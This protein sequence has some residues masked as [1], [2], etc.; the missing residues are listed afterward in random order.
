M[1]HYQSCTWP[2]AAF[3]SHRR[4]PGKVANNTFAT[5][6]VRICVD[7]GDVY[8]CVLQFDTMPREVTAHVEAKFT[9]LLLCSKHAEA[10]FVAAAPVIFCMC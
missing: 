6:A 1:P 8:K 9:D 2:S 4:R 7:A 3:G 10:S 5:L